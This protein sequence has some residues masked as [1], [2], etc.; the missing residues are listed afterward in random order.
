MLGDGEIAQGLGSALTAAGHTVFVS[1]DVGHL[2]E[3]LAHRLPQVL[4]V[5]TALLDP[6]VAAARATALAVQ[7]PLVLLCGDPAADAQLGHQA[8]AMAL[9]PW[10]T[11]SSAWAGSLALWLERHTEVQALRRSQGALESALE[12]SRCISTAVGVLAERHH[13]STDAAF[14]M[15]RKQ[16]RDRRLPVDDVAHVIIDDHDRLETT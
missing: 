13:V 7:W 1:D 9:L 4:L 11:Q 10:N 8:G 12:R 16:S 6:P 5:H 15:M 2:D 3:L 14:K